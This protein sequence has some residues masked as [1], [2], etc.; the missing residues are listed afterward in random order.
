MSISHDFSAIDD[1]ERKFAQRREEEYQAS[2]EKELSPLRA[3]EK[4]T[5]A[6]ADAQII[7]AQAERRK[8]TGYAALATGLGVGA[9]AFGLSYLVK[10]KIIETM[11]LVTETKTVDRRDNQG[12]GD[13]KIR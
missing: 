8:K 12:G 11:K 4:E 6:Q 9:A 7:Q 1:L 13:S 3:K 5:N 10:P 2:I